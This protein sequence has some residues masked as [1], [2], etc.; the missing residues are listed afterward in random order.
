MKRVTALLAL[1]VICGLAFW[2]DLSHR[3]AGE[4]A[5]QAAAWE[6][7]KADRKAELERATAEVAHRS[8][9]STA[10]PAAALPAVAEKDSLGP[11]ASAQENARA[12]QPTETP[13]PNLALNAAKPSVKTAAPS[14]PVKPKKQWQDPLAREA[15]SYVGLDAMAEVVWAEA[16]ANPDLPSKEREDLIEDLNEEGFPDPKHITIDDLPLIVSRL[17]LIEG[18]ASV[19]FDE[20]V[21]PHFQEAYKDLFNMY[22]RLVGQ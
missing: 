22:V 14:G 8:T 6:R 16:I 13:V 21:Y 11:G 2:I 10:V 5:L 18:Y 3:K 17:A 19:G 4:R 1:T 12:V 20:E 15:L 7:V 9:L